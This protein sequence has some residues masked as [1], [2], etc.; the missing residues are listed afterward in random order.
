MEYVFVDGAQ[1]VGMIPVDIGS[2]GVDAYAMSPHKWV[3]SPKGLGLLYVS[4]ALRSQLPRMWHKTP[5]SRMD[6]T[7][8]SMPKLRLRGVPPGC[9]RFRP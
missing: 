6:G 3:Q 5:E 2:A 7:A 4:Q 1:S 8:E 9:G